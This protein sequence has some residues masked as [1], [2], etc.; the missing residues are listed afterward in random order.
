MANQW[1]ID[2]EELA[3]AAGFFDGEGCFCYT[4]SG[5]YVGVRVA[6]TALEP[7]ERFR[8]ALVNVGK[9]YGPYQQKHR[10]RWSK[11]PQFAYQVTGHERVQAIAAMLWFKLGSAKRAQATRALDQAIHCHR[12]H[13]KVKGHGG[14]AQ[15][16]TN[17]WR[18]RRERRASL[19]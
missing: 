14:C 2:R 18:G 9:I 13:L 11:K 4:K 1:G 17:Y 12:G 6:Q 8:T 7:L 10:D 16:T 15:C 19:F 5:R 3:W